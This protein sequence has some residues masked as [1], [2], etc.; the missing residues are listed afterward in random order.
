M[1]KQSPTIAARFNP[2]PPHYVL[3][4][5]EF[6]HLCEVARIPE[7]ENFLF[8][9]GLIVP[10]AFAVGGNWPKTG[11]LPSTFFLLNFIVGVLAGLVAV[12]QARAWRLKRN[13][14]RSFV[15]ELKQRPENRLAVAPATQTPY[16]K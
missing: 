3:T 1:A 12:F 14:F 4:E 5:V 16:V 9:I 8:L 2:D 10:C 6:K 13:S 15:D 7:K 11:D